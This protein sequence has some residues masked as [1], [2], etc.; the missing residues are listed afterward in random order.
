MCLNNE[1]IVNYTQDRFR[2]IPS[3]TDHGLKYI[4]AEKKIAR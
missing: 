1:N 3:K 4:L 2:I